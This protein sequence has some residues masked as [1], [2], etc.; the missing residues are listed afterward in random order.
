MKLEHLR[1]IAIL[2]QE[3]NFSRAADCISERFKLPEFDQPQLSKQLIALEKEIGK[4]IGKEV[5]LF[6]RTTHS[7]QLTDAG[8]IFLEAVN[9][10]IARID[11]GITRAQ[12][13]S[14]GKLGKLTVGLIS[15]ITNSMLPEILR[16]FHAS[17]PNVE[18]IWQEIAH[19]Q[20]QCLRDREIDIGFLYSP[21]NLQTYEDLRFRPVLRESLIIALPETHILVADPKIP[22]KALASEAFILPSSSMTFGL[23][24]QIVHCCK[25]KGF[26]PK[27]AQEAN[28]MLTILGLV[29]GGVGIALLPENAQNL[30]RSGVVYRSVEGEL[31]VLE[32]AMIWRRED[33]NSPILQNFIQVIQKITG[34]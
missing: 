11:D 5:R 22:L 29:A 28:F 20:I 15:S 33:D 32:V 26:E 8:K 24:E 27:V 9:S 2:A 25:Q 17:F 34:S 6:D 12:E 4:E 19:P 13:V 7:V 23:A 31:P 30:Q 10:A 21:D 3:L 1:N 16:V 14:Q 18:L